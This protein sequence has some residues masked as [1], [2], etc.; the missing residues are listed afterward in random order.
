MMSSKIRDVAKIV[1]DGVSPFLGERKYLATGGLD[2]SE[3]GELFTV[4]YSNKP[5]RADLKAKPGDVIVAR[6]KDTNKVLLIDEKLSNY[7]F[8]TGFLVLRPSQVVLP[9]YLY[10]YLKSDSF[11]R[12]KNKYCT[13]ATQKSI[14]NEN[15]S[16]ILLPLNN[17]DRQKEMVSILHEVEESLIKSNKEMELI[18]IFLNS[19]FIKIFE[20]GIFMKNW[21][22]FELHKVIDKAVDCP[23]STPIYTKD[24][25]DAY[26]CLRSSDIQNGFID[27]TTTKYVAFEEY[28]KRVKRYKPIGGEIIFC[29]EGAR[30]GNSAIISSPTNICLG[31]RMMLFVPNSK[32]TKEF[33]WGLMN[34]EYFN[35]QIRKNTAGAA[36]PRVNIKDILKFQ[37]FVPPLELQNQFSYVYKEVEKIKRNIELQSQELENQFQSL[38]QKY[39][40]LN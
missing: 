28:T 37:V 38:M 24:I 8:S 17:I 15:F 19:F 39:F 6:M 23:H 30:L 35:A 9:E 21:D 31:Q 32:V 1:S 20:S 14:N 3:V 7:I 22:R 16:K 40:S 12:I 11:Q 10:Y 4:T 2:T 26:P 36:A 29:R 33:L 27:N 5:S 13:G 34:N 25:N 18:G